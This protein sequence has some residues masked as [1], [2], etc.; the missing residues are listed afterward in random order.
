MAASLEIAENLVH[1]IGRYVEIQRIASHDAIFLE[2]SRISVHS[3]KSRY[4][5]RSGIE[6]AHTL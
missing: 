6:T 2:M 4:T 5:R 3:S 1:E